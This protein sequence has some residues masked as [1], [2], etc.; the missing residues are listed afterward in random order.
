MNFWQR[1]EER[2]VSLIDVKETK[3]SNTEYGTYSIAQDNT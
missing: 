2:I 3:C 1:Q